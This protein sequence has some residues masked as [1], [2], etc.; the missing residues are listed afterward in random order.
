MLDQP[1]RLPDANP[2]DIL[3]DLIGD[4]PP[5]ANDLLGDLFGLAPLAVLPPQAPAVVVEVVPALVPDLDIAIAFL[6]SLRPEGYVQLVG[7]RPDGIK[8]GCNTHSLRS[9]RVTGNERVIIDHLK[10]QHAKGW[11]TYYAVNEVKAGHV[12]KAAKAEVTRLV[13]LFGDIDPAD[14]EPGDDPAEHHARERVRLLALADTLARDPVAPP[15]FIVDSGGGIQMVWMLE[16]PVQATPDNIALLEDHGRGVAVRFR[17]EGF[18]ADDV[19]SVDHLMRLPGCVNFPKGKK[20]ARG[21][22]PALARLLHTGGRRYRLDELGKV[23]PAIDAGRLRRTSGSA[24]LPT[25]CDLNVDQL[26]YLLDALPAEYGANRKNWLNVCWAVRRSWG[27]VGWE[28]FD[29]WSAADAGGNYDPA[30][31]REMWDATPPGPIDHRWLINEAKAGCAERGEVFSLRLPG[32]RAEDHFEEVD[33]P[34]RG[35][36]E[37]D[38]DAEK[39]KAPDSPFLPAMPELLTRAAA[40]GPETSPEDIRDLLTAAAALR[41]KEIELTALFRAVKSATKCGMGELRAD[42]RAIQ[43]DNRDAVDLGHTVAEEVVKMSFDGRLVRADDRSFWRYT[44]THW[45]RVTDEVVHGRCIARARAH[46]LG[47]SDLRRVADSALRLLAGMQARDGD[48]LGLLREPPP[49]INCTNGELWLSADGTAELRPHRPE[50]YLK[51]CLPIA[52]DPGAVCPRY[53]RTVLEVF[54]AATDPAGMV[55]HW[56]EFTGYVM[57]PCRDLPSWWLLY[58]NGANG[59]SMLIS[60]LEALLSPE[61]VLSTNIARAATDRFLI[62]SMVGKLMIRDDDV[63]SNTKLPDKFLKEFGEGKATTG[64]LKFKSHFAFVSVAVPVLLANNWPKTDDVSHGYRRRARVVPFARQFEEAEQDLT[65]GR[66]IIAN[67]LA[68]VLN[69]SLEGLRRLRARGRFD[70]PADCRVAKERFFQSAN[71]V[72]GFVAA[73]CCVEVGAKVIANELW[74]AYQ[75]WASG[76]GLRVVPTR[77]GFYDAIEALGYPTGEIN[78]GVAVYGLVLAKAA[79]SD[80]AADEFESI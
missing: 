1:R 65:L 63:N 50:S 61:A 17:T 47:D 76:E 23:A 2:V 58:G 43:K 41:P 4:L 30:G 74:L 78:K 80:K 31:N 72:A 12:G 77:Q 9:C 42:F 29:D 34:E 62:G 51:H 13:A 32:T 27:E 46:D 64:E 39:A 28:A 18:N 49:V 57:Q 25:P 53:D 75:T 52:Y 70:D 67:E 56:H 33:I 10:S 26:K 40:M 14:L 60:I 79:D 7:I 73:K 35:M 38:A 22:K 3:A 55:R 16:S 45:T 19:Q 71:T 69:R 59:K 48:V 5:A 20:R 8:D 21:Q 68:G 15:T 66:Y 11:G 6:R 24:S 36:I 37:G 54:G 44:G